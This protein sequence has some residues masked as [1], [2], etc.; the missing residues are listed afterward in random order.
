MGSSVH[1]P[2]N[3]GTGGVHVPSNMSG[4][5]VP[6]N[7]SGVHVPS[8][9]TGSAHI[10]SEMT[11]AHTG[12]EESHFAGKG[13][14]GHSETRHTRV[15]HSSFHHGPFEMSHRYG[16][17]ERAARLDEE[18]ARHFTPASSGSLFHGQSRAGYEAEHSF[19]ERRPQG[20]LHEHEFARE[21][22]G[23]FHTRDVHQFD[24][25]EFARWRAGRWYR[26]WRDGRWGWWW[27]V[28]NSWYW[29][30]KPYYPYPMVVTAV[31]VDAPDVEGAEAAQVDIPDEGPSV[32]QL[33]PIEPLPAPPAPI[34]AF[35]G[36]NA[37]PCCAAGA[38]RTNSPH[39]V[40]GEIMWQYR[41]PFG[42]L[43]RVENAALKD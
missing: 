4:V 10:P 23:D 7:M 17:G 15:T 9:M 20:E 11:G 32:V 21:H 8:N 16:G 25:A 5:H 12:M 42:A 38:L 43:Y 22:E 24:H 40:P 33:P 41:W 31:Y 18:R 3:M 14:T 28:H 29:Y 39:P 1:L 37:G 2:S 27:R 26:I 13:E 30:R 19:A 36:S 35:A 6:S 34:Y